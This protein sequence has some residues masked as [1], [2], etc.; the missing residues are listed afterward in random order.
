M[1]IFY[2]F[3]ECVKNCNLVYFLSLFVNRDL[4]DRVDGFVSFFFCGRI[5]SY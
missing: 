4:K 1:L 2:D 5:L 3:V